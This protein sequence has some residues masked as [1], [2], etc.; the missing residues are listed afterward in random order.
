M[1]CTMSYRHTSFWMSHTDSLS[2]I[3][4]DRI[5]A[6]CGT[7]GLLHIGADCSGTHPHLQHPHVREGEMNVITVTLAPDKIWLILD[8][9]G[10][11]HTQNESFF[12]KHASHL[13]PTTSLKSVCQ[14]I[15]LHILLSITI[16][17]HTN[18]SGS[19]GAGM[20]ATAANHLPLARVGSHCVDAVKCWATG[21]GQSATLIN[22]WWMEIHEDK[23]RQKDK[24]KKKKGDL[25]YRFRAQETRGQLLSRNQSRPTS[26][27]CTP[28]V[29][30][31]VC[32]CLTFSQFS[33]FSEHF[34]CTPFTGA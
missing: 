6:N 26:H 8:A 14:I 7:A 17:N 2:G 27:G 4:N 5:Q 11:T 9:I 34:F 1:A 12:I 23:K 15:T 33:H 28:S 29:N 19:I 20:I 22:V 30:F 10:E 13:C 25:K 31:V 24:K 3:H 21:L 16:T 18:T 32:V